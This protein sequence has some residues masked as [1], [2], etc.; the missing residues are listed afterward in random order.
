MVNGRLA[1][2]SPATDTDTILYTCPAN[3][4]ASVTLSIARRSV[5]KDELVRVALMDSAIIG[6]LVDEDYIEYDSGLTNVSLTISAG[7]SIVVR[8][9]ASTVS[10]VL[11]GF[12]ETL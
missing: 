12:E 2:S 8:A 1:A 7:E 6:D 10:F 4:V 5:D 9:N 11:H 3:I